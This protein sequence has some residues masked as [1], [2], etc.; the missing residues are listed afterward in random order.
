MKKHIITFLSATLLGIASFAQV[1]DLPRSTP[2]RE[3]VPSHVVSTLLDSLFAIPQTNIHSVMMLRNGK[4]IAEVYPT[5]FKA[6]YQHTQYSCSKTFVS[7]AIGLAVDANLLRVTDR[8]ATFF[9][10]KLPDE[11]SPELAAMSIHDLLIMASGIDPDG[12][13]RANN[14]NWIE[15]LLAKTVKTPGKEFKY[16]SLCTYL[17]SAIVQKVTGKTV[18]SY[19]QE[20]IFNELHIEKVSWEESP[21]GITTGGWGLFIQPESLAKMGQLLLQK[22]SWNGKQL[23][24][25]AWVNQMMHSHIDT[26]DG[27][28]YG[29]QMWEAS[30]DG[31]FRADGR[32]GQY[33]VVMPKQDMVVVVTQCSNAPNPWLITRLLAPVV[34]KEV[35]ITDKDYE[36][37]QLKLQKYSYPTVGGKAKSSIAKKLS[38]KSFILADNQFGWRKISFEQG[39][40]QLLVVITNEQ[41]IRS[42]LSSGYRHWNTSWT[43]A[44]PPYSMNAQQKFKGIE[45]PFAVAACYGWS[46]TNTLRLN[47][48]YVNWISA[49]D[50]TLTF[51]DN[52][53]SFSVHKNYESDV[54]Q[55]TGSYK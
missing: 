22:G 25:E 52:S 37:L 21:E 7:A 55:F 47:L 17:L 6:E 39:D 46:S 31:A 27:R 38:G 8:V 12:S 18:L 41:G 43:E 30:K 14:I 19:L 48:Q 42:E 50:V 36:N 34:Q 33:I 5:P 10:D 4:V 44:H 15:P 13:L 40:K 16:D 23:L 2:E 35:L 49:L 32:F 11:V 1:N 29:Y 54:P 9:P 51:K 45:G 26:G 28:Y 24:S 20:N 3:G 53:V